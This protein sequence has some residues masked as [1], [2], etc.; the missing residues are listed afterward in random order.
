MRFPKFLPE[1]GTIG[2]AAP[3]FGCNTEPYRTAF[4]HSLD[5][6]H[7]RG[8]STLLGPNV[9]VGE[10][11]GISNTPEKCGAELTEM[12]CTPE[13]DVLISC[14]G[15]E[16]MCETMDHVDFEALRAAAPKWFM[17]YSDNTNMGFLLTTLC[18]TASIYGPCAASFGME[19]W[20]ASIDDAYALLTGTKLTEKGY[21][22]YEVE[23]F[24]SEENPLAPYHVTEPRSI[25]TW[26]AEAGITG[27]PARQNGDMMENAAEQKGAADPQDIHMTGRLLGG[28]L[29]CLVNLCGTKFDEVKAFDERYAE[30]G[31]IWFLEACDLNVYSIR[32]ALWHLDRAGWF[33]HVKGFLIG[34]P[35]NGEEMFGLDRY[36]AVVDILGKYQVPILMDLDIGHVSP[37]MP[38]I[39]GAMADVTCKGQDFTID[40][41]LE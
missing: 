8:Y 1:G 32:R 28:C 37:M 22:L 33:S 14:G 35:L 24:K 18:D 38:L 40:M 6:W 12:Y 39:S 27:M 11:I 17:G 13:S 3:S 16:L 26:T 30:D 23:P 20:H 7:Q 4:D 10:G 31:M 25:V 2:F 34:R 29:D 15:G 19:P 41:R 9:Y 5:L 36:R 21:S